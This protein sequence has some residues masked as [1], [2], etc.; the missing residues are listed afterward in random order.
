MVDKD[1]ARGGQQAD[2]SKSTRRSTAFLAVAV[3]AVLVAVATFGWRHYRSDD[4]ADPRI[5]IDT[6]A[7][8][9][10]GSAGAPVSGAAAGD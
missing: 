10:T 9:A 8:T 5:V 4:G 3:I 6:P 1:D 7:G 2:N